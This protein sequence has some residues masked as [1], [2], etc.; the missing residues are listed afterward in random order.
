M[1]TMKSATVL[2]L[3]VIAA[4]GLG[5]VPNTKPV[6]IHERRPST[7][8]SGPGQSLEIPPAPGEVEAMR[9]IQADVSVCMK[10]ARSLADR[11][12]VEQAATQYDR[13]ASID[14][15]IS[16]RQSDLFRA[17]SFLIQ[18]RYQDAATIYANAFPKTV[19]S[20]GTSA[21]AA[22]S[23][24]E[25][26][27]FPEALR[28]LTPHLSGSHPVGSELGN[29]D[30]PTA[31]DL[32]EKNISATAY[33]LAARYVEGYLGQPNLALR[34]LKKANHLAP[35]NASIC[36]LTGK[37]DMR[38]GRYKEAI[39]YLETAVKAMQ[40]DQSQAVPRMLTQCK[41]PRR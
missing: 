12:L 31:K 22:V 4:V 25:T 33:L 20:F 38:L 2:S 18:K 26:G 40:S 41:Q 14:I 24:A 32:S 28:R 3:A 5:Q 15:A 34:Y 35:G 27:N 30:L 17:E 1:K 21:F 6:K 23:F 10:A 19:S 8:T 39:P 13:A 7:K 9:K 16:E 29:L 37:L 36:F 11:G